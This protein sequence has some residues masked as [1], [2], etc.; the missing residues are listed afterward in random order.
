MSNSIMLA[1]IFI[2][3]FALDLLG[4]VNFHSYGVHIFLW[5]RRLFVIT[6]KNQHIDPL[7]TRIYRSIKTKLVSASNA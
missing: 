7:W 6:L 5:G 4:G 3:Y 2:V 1:L